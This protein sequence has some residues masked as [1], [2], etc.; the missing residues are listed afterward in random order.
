[1]SKPNE[2]LGASVERECRPGASE[3][4]KGGKA[5]TGAA[6]ARK[7][8]TEQ[9]RKAALVRWANHRKEKGMK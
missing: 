1:M 2:P 5:G 6:K 3:I 8:S 7:V 4:C 9:A